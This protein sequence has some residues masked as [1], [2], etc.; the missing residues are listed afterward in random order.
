MCLGL[1]HYKPLPLKNCLTGTLPTDIICN[2]E[3]LHT[4]ALDGLH[5]AEH[6]EV[7]SF[8]TLHSFLRIFWQVD[9]REV[10]QV[11]CSI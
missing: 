10:Y 9:R 7:D 6:F 8:Q 1:R 4:L 3:S 5:R 2:S 11:A